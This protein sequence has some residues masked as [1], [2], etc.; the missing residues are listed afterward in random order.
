MIRPPSD[1]VTFLFTDIEGS[2][3][4]WEKYPDAMQRALAEHDRLLRQVFSAHYGYV[5]KTMGDAFYVAFSSP[6]DALQ[7]VLAAQRALQAHTW[8]ETPIKV[9]MA[10]HTGEA[11][12]RDQDY[13]GP[14]LNRA[15]RLLAAGHGGQILLSNTTYELL[16]DQLPPTIGVR[17]MGDRRLKDLIRPE[18]IY[19]VLAPDLPLEFPPL[20]TLDARPNNLPVQITSFVGRQE[21]IKDLHGLIEKH[22]LVTLTGPGGA[23]KTRLSLQ[24]GAD[25]IDDFEHGVWLVEL[26]P[27]TDEN[28]V[29]QVVAATLGVPEDSQA[30]LIKTLADHL[31]DRQ[32]LL[33]LDN[34]EHLLSAC[35]GL[36]DRLLKAAPRL[37]ILVSSREALRIRGEHIYRVP[38]LAAPDPRRL[39][40]TA[41]LTQYES[42]RLFI[43][44]ALAV[45]P[46]FQITNANA[47]ALADICYRLDGIPLALELAAARVRSMPLEKIAERLSD[48]FRLLTGGDRSALP[49][50]Q[51][52]RSLI[53]WSYDLLSESEQALLRR[54]AVFA[55]GWE[56][57]AAEAVA[58]GP[59][60]DLF[61]VLDLLGRLV[62]KSL[63]FLDTGGRYHQLETINQYALEK[64]RL[65][66]EE[67]AARLQHIHFFLAL[68]EAVEPQLHG[69]EEAQGLLRLRREQENLLAAI[70]WCRQ[71]GEPLGLELR[72]A[73][74][75]RDYW[76]ASG[77]LNVGYQALTQALQRPGVQI[78]ITHARA[79]QAL[80]TMDYWAG[81]YA[82]SERHLQTGLALARQS[83]DLTAVASTLSRI[84]DA[85]LALEQYA[86]AREACDESIHMARQLSNDHL[87][88]QAFCSR[89]DIYRAE[90]DLDAA[91]A[92]YE[93]S[94][95]YVR[96]MGAPDNIA[97]L[98]YNL[99]IIALLRAAP[100]PARLM[101]TEF[102]EISLALEDPSLEILFIYQTAAL[103]ALQADWPAAARFYAA[104]LVQ[105]EHTGYPLVPVDQASLAPLFD[106]ARQALG[107]PAFAAAQSSGAALSFETAFLEA[108]HWL[109]AASPT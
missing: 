43:D 44:R 83:E 72:L 105:A 53:D 48:R 24:V 34:C 78:G 92:N 106:R 97:S 59:N 18:H 38:P 36:A 28:F 75:L 5:F 51:T 26:A 61:D 57:E 58:A 73:Y 21:Q 80:G 42:V 22:P 102:L 101:L 96:R 104:A 91:Q 79:W 25:L 93:E 60:V 76:Q 89:A 56:L 40:S 99:T 20:K 84:A 31:H 107:D 94:L 35:A 9:R 82:E 103:G 85:L 109:S 11:E 7:A 55:G 66:G 98:L 4:L 13:Y 81:R 8:D 16:R 65:A 29:P 54:L 50:Q 3:R 14:P 88:A 37:K 45:Q 62:D 87:L 68:A 49:R 32:L 108:Q 15:A 30:T 86:A 52:L 12:S 77:Y 71:I 33:I 19:Q 90:D 74:S 27:L 2:T 39:P 47:P 6:S 63:I 17:D 70:R 23:G 64:L 46:A 67:P 1:T 95:F 69:P 10:L 100:G 41:I